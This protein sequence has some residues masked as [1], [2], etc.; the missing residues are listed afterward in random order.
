M[1]IVQLNN[2][3]E[4]IVSC[5][6]IVKSFYT[7]SVYECWNAEEVKYGSI[8]FCITKTQMR[9]RTMTYDA[10]IY[11]GDRLLE[12]KSNR[13]AIWSDA[14]QVIQSIIGTVNSVDGEITISY[15]YNLTLFEQKFADELAGAYA[16]ISIEVEG[17]GECGDL[18]Y[19]YEDEDGIK[20][21]SVVKTFTI[22]G[23]YDIIPSDGFD[24]ISDVKVIVD[25]PIQSKSVEFNSNGSYNVTPDS[26]YAAMDNVA[27]N[28]N[29]PLQSKSVTYSEAGDYQ[30]TPDPGYEALSKV[31]VKVSLEGKTQI[32]NGFR[33]TGG[34]MSLVEWD[35][36]DWS[37]VYDAA[38][39]FKGCS[40]SDPNWFDRFK[41]GFNGKLLSGYYMF[42]N[43]N[44][45][46]Q[47]DFTGINTSEMID[48]RY[49]FSGSKFT[50]IKGLNALNMTDTT[51]MFQECK[52][53][54]SIDIINTHNVTTMSSMFS[55]CTSLQSISQLDTSKV[56]S[57]G[58]MFRECKSLESI[59]YLNTSNVILMDNIFYRCEKLTTIPQLDTSKVVSMKS[60]FS[61]CKSLESIPH[62]DTSN[63]TSMSSIFE[64]CEKLT[65]I[66]QLD[67]SKVVSMDGMFYYCKSLQ[68]I[69][70]LVTSKA[71]YM[72]NMF[73]RCSS[74]TTVPEL[75]IS[76]AISI[77]DMFSD[78]T[79]LVEVRFKGDPSKLEQ[80]SA[81]LRVYTNGVFYY[82]SRYDYS[83][84]INVLP[85]SWT[86]V[87]YDVID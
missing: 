6:E 26:E 81:F 46:Q 2:F 42:K 20:L 49:M 25:V 75:D 36:Y 54:E 30:V 16:E 9:E 48:G 52:S 34:D 33:F 53:L 37:M 14:T 74:L 40:S 11:Y 21:E 56:T 35:K 87:P 45:N 41:N 24:A 5:T 38:E 71:K 62:L 15:P 69:P 17:V 67:T 61:Y 82:D 13:N 12:D 4:K 58:E 10:I 22:N 70:Q 84:I 8:S 55:Y 7:N 86:A 80:Y 83:K 85:S 66:P 76:S 47:I 28:V 32:P 27:V 79:S 64:G 51:C 39:F 18:L 77:T 3:I 78:C 50:N 43:F 73:W 59:P 68:T 23:E 1:N 72:Q 44:S 57:M 31:D 63:V 19:G 65:T 60:M 29:I